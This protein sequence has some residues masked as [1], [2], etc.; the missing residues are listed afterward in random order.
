MHDD[1]IRRAQGLLQAGMA[2]RALPIVR[3]ALALDPAD[4][5]LHL[6]AAAA[7]HDL[8]G[9]ADAERHARIAAGA[10]ELAA[11]AWQLV[12]AA[13]GATGERRDEAVD[14]ARRA[15]QLDPHAAD[16]RATLAAM[17]VRAGR[18]ADAIAEAR[19]SVAL[20]DD[21]PGRARALAVLATAHA[22]NRDRREAREHARRAVA[23]DPTAVH[24]LDTLMRVQLATGQRAEAM[25]SALA[26]LRQAPTEAAPP[27][28]ARI[29]LYLVEHR[30]V[31]WLLVVSFV[32]PL[33]VFGGGGALGALD[34]GSPHAGLVVRLG[35]ALGLA[36]TG[37]VLARLLAP[38]RDAGVRRAVARFARRSPRSWFVGVVVALMA[39]SYLAALVLGELAFPGVPAP[40]LLLL[41]AWCAHGLAARAVP[42]PGA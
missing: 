16:R 23:H 14:A 8:G 42:T 32:V 36:A 2:D 27:V 28:L 31:G 38:L 24:L 6:L 12:A 35:G 40:F 29:A 34:D 15:V 18:S 26:V 39:L 11:G 19:Q 20:A 41:V 22:A 30:L 3:A 17:L 33:V 21:D 9:H 7:H 37:G 25:A 4:A 5:R 10:P 1:A 13:I